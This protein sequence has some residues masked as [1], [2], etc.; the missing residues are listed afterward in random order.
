MLQQISTAA[1]HDERSAAGARDLVFVRL[2][3][4]RTLT[5]LPAEQA[6]AD[7]SAD[8]SVGSGAASSTTPHSNITPSAERVIV[9]DVDDNVVSLSWWR[10]FVKRNH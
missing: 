4:R 6:T 2:A 9:D 3:I 7:G 1:E 10:R 5:R 8:G